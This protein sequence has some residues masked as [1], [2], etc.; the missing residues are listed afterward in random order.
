MTNM[1]CDIQLDIAGNI[2]FI[3]GWSAVRDNGHGRRIYE[4]QIDLKRASM[5]VL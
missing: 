5:E 2:V 4:P 3:R 1:T